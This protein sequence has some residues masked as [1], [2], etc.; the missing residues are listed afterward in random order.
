MNL[1]KRS[2]F[3]KISDQLG[4]YSFFDKDV[5]GEEI[6]SG[7]SRSSRFW[8][9]G[10][11]VA[12]F[13][14]LT[15]KLFSLQVQEGY[16]N[17]KLANGN[18]LRNIPISAPRGMIVD[19][20]NHSLVENEPVYQL[21]LDSGKRKQVATFDSKI[22]DLVGVSKSDIENIIKEN[23]NPTEYIV[24]KDKIPREEALLMKSRIVDFNTFEVMPSY[25]RRYPDTSLSHILGYVGKPNQ[26]E[27]QNGGSLII[28]GTSGKS[29]LE[30]T[31]DQY[32]Q[33]AP[34]YRRAE[35]DVK[36]KVLS[37]TSAQDPQVGNT[38]VTSIDKGLQDFTTEALKAR[39]DELNTRGAAIVT[40]VRDGSIKALVSIPGYDNGKL[41]S[42]VT[43]EEYQA[44]A[45]DPS[46]P[47]FDR[48]I[49]GAYPAGSA[50][51]P[52]IATS[53]LEDGIVNKDLAFDTP[54]FIQIGQ[55]KFPDWKDHGLTNIETAIAQSNNI[56]F[57]ALGGGWGPIKNGLGPEG[58][59]KGLEK[60][61][62]GSRTGIDLTGEQSGFIPTAQWKKK[63][64][65][66]S[67]FIGNTYNMSIGQGDLLV[68]PIQI[69]TGTTAIA[70]GGKL[71]EPHLVTKITD[72]AGQL[73]KEFTP[74]DTLVKSD[75]FS[76]GN[77]ETVRDGMRQTVT[78]GS[79]F[80]VFGS[81]F[82]IEVAGKT[83]TAQFGS[84]G[85]T[86]A[87]FTSYAP[88]DDPK[89]SVTV[90]IEAGGEGY[91]S[92]APVAKQIYQWWNDNSN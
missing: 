9:F 70:N 6:F 25:Q 85:K 37:L 49:S 80:S 32:L 43:Q 50:I 12:F 19:A 10:L 61:G 3:G 72:S 45:N 27:V 78:S 64:T 60:F 2:G 73:I 92:A 34:G 74:S 88:Y 48:A 17:L 30:K 65:G 82:P 14:I 35:V 77:L 76:S 59:K 66:E 53:A 38:I 31:Y 67:W 47:L 91:E 56:F 13:V 62:F 18:R 4:E 41:S 8:T 26:G 52:F 55:W 46:Q 39:T 22:F 63:Q 40:D 24:I 7:T 89:I 58:I 86:H 15:M 84:E 20:K 33:G 29:G 69:A 83:G 42:G 75:I 21:V 79:A 54:P 51:K 90:L 11:I 1:F 87:W 16:V 44:L 71:F 68:T 81:D 57:F 28:N 5:S 36:G 23:K